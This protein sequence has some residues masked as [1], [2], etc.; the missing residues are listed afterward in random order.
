MTMER[1]PLGIIPTGEAA[2][3]L[4]LPYNVRDYGAYGDGVHDDT[5]AIQAAI[6]AVPADGGTV[7]F[8][9]GIYNITSGLTVGN[10]SSAGPSSIHNVFLRGDGTGGLGYLN[11][12][13]DSPGFTRV[14]WT[15]AANS[16]A[17]ML[18]F[19][20]EMFGGGMAGIGIDGNNLAGY[21]LIVNHVVQGDWDVQVRNCTALQMHI[22][23]QTNSPA[24]G[25][26]A[27]H[28][29]RIILFVP[30]GANGLNIDGA[31][32]GTAGDVDH[33]VFDLI[34]IGLNG[35]N[36]EGLVLGFCDFNDFRIVEITS[37]AVSGS[38]KGLILNGSQTNFPN[39]NHFGRLSVS[40]AGLASYTSGGTPQN[41]TVEYFDTGDGA[42]SVPDGYAGFAGVSQAQ[43]GAANP[44]VP[45]GEGPAIRQSDVQNSL[46]TT[47]ASTY[48]ASFTAGR[49]GNYLLAPYLRVVTAAT[50]V[51]LTAQWQDEDGVT[52]YYTW[53]NAVSEPTGSVSLSPV[54]IHATEGTGIF[55]SITVGTVNQVYASATMT[56]L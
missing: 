29:R 40:A 47:T 45:F 53:L 19:L 54:T 49:T 39:A 30:S 4:S 7:Y 35:T 27:N 52:R 1:W 56:A 17:V 38:T 16:S 22:T 10:G 42:G 33:N 37:G 48:I 36:N 18:N 12:T 21:G 51:T 41:N 5:T 11:G 25:C 44:R 13:V 31:S 32:S 55:I 43:G 3:L 8:P 26:A 20:G 2:R 9:A 15:G 34:V 14:V 50:T 6:N 28:F 46:I 24:E 23:T